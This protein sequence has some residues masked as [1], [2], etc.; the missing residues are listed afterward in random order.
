MVSL[1]EGVQAVAVC[2]T[3]LEETPYCQLF[4]HES[5]GHCGGPYLD[6]LHEALSLSVCW[7]VQVISV[8]QA[9]A[10]VLRRTKGYTCSS[11]KEGAASLSNLLV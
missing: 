4:I 1:L 11:E 3:A 5:F 6:T 9:W 2:E 8:E 10:M 7:R